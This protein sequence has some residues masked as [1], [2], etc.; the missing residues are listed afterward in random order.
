[1]N[2]SKVYFTDLRTNNGGNLP[3]KLQRLIRAAG[4]GSIDM[5][6]KFVAIKL[7]FGEPGN[8]SFL[9]PNYA[10]AVADVVKEQGGLPFLTDCNTLYVG[11]R[12]HALEHIEAA[13]ENGFSP[14]STGCQ[15]IIGDGLKGTDEAE[16]RVEGGEYVKTAKI[17]RAVMDAD[18]FISLTHFKG[19]E[20]TGF[21]GAIKNIGMGCGSRAG[22]MEQH[23]SGKVSSDP[24][25][26]VGCG[27]CAKACAQGAIAYG[28]DRK[29]VIDAEKCVGCGRCLGHCNFDAIHNRNWNAGD[30]LN[31]KMAEYTKAVLAGRPSFHISMVIDISPSCDCCS[32]NDAPILPDIGMFASFDPVAL[33]Q[34]CADACKR[35][36]PLPNSQLAENMAA[37]GFCDHHDHF[38]NNA[39]ETDWRVCLEHAEKIGVG[40]RAYELVRVK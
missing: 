40:T 39:P 37:P 10:K 7:H 24:Q 4:I 34:A 36:Q 32:T 23:C 6:K 14:L 33:D 30:L 11:R 18:V 17:G 26:C 29:A 28:K 27:A 35:Q 19:H 15:I 31:R 8:L 20:S 16:V 3:Q 9:R 13:Q 21:G 12:K 5:E 38:I 1:M 2:P 22:K 25:K